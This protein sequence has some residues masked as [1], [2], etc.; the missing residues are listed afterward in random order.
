MKIEV[1]QAIDFKPLDVKINYIPKINLTSIVSVYHID[2]ETNKGGMIPTPES[3]VFADVADQPG[4]F[5]QIDTT[6]F[7]QAVYNAFPGGAFVKLNVIPPQLDQKDARMGMFWQ[8]PAFDLRAIYDYFESFGCK[9]EGP[10][11]LHVKL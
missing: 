4:F 7:M 3:N 6:L 5:I 2:K 10:M 8:A 11:K 1:P 9:I